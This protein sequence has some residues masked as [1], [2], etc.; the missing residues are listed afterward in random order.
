MYILDTDIVSNIIKPLPSQHL[1]S[2]LRAVPS[3]KLSISA[4]TLLELYTGLF[5]SKNP[6]PIKEFIEEW[7]IKTLRVLDFTPAQ[8]Y[9]AAKIQADLKKKGAILDWLDVMIA[10]AAITNE[11]ILVTGNLKH[12]NRIQGLMIENWL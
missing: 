3:S 1:I 4:I 10:S 11:G 12:F 5:L 7:V 6:V 8:S 2:K 9:M